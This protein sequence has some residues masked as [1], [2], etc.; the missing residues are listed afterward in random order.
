MPPFLGQ[1][2]NSGLRDAANLAWKLDMVLHGRASDAILDT[3]ERERKQN[4]TSIVAAAVEIGRV[5]CGRVP[6]PEPDSASDALAA[7]AFRLPPLPPGP[8]VGDGGGAVAAQAV[9]S[10]GARFDDVVGNRFLV[11]RA[12][13]A[14]EPSL[15]DQFWDDWWRREVGALVATPSAYPNFQAELE[16]MLHR[17]GAPAIVVRPDRHVLYAG[18]RLNDV[19]QTVREELRRDPGHGDHGRTNDV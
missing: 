11:L 1:G 9:S 8:F 18:D 5:V 15:R 2:M 4:V 12:D 6:L 13:R 17:A 16:R 10:D 3:Y 19:S 7:L 14:S